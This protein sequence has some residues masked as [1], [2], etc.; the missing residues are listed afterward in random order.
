VAFPAQRASNVWFVETG[1]PSPGA[2]RALS[3]KRCA[4]LLREL[5]R[6][7]K[8]PDVRAV[9]KQGELAAR[10]SRHFCQNGSWHV[11]EHC[12]DAPRTASWYKLRDGIISTSQTQHACAL[13]SLKLSCPVPCARL[14]ERAPV[15]PLMLSERLTGAASQA[16]SALCLLCKAPCH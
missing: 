6:W 14:D 9:C 11:L 5:W 8:R 13:Q 10:R 2:L 3:C 1:R 15:S 12:S 4:S 7:C 16:L